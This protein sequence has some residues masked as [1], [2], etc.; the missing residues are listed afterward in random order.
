VPDVMPAGAQ[1]GLGRAEQT[2][3]GLS[4]IRRGGIA[5]SEV[6]R[7]LRASRGGGCG[8]HTQLVTLPQES[9]VQP[10]G[11]LG[12]LRAGWWS[13]LNSSDTCTWHSESV[14][15]AGRSHTRDSPCHLQAS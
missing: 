4:C 14:I 9:V 7:A 5:S 3:G 13:L 10:R 6:A 2:G 15:A 11:W 12:A 1:A 8:T